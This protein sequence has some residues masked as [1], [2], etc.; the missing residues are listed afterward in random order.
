MGKIRECV[1]KLKVLTW[2]R[3]HNYYEVRLLEVSVSDGLIVTGPSMRWYH[4]ISQIRLQNSVI[5][6]SGS[7]IKVPVQFS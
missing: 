5:V 6:Y 7:Q 4:L 3:V 2:D 1:P